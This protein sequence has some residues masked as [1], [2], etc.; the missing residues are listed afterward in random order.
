LAPYLYDAEAG[1]GVSPAF[2]GNTN[3]TG[4]ECNL[5]ICQ[6]GGCSGPGEG[7]LY[8]TEKVA[9]VHTTDYNNDPTDGDGVGAYEFQ[10][11]FDSF[12]IQ[13][14]NPQDLVF[15]NNGSG[16]VD[17]GGAPFLAGGRGAPNCSMS[18]T[19]ENSVRF[20]CVTVG[21]NDGPN[22]N[23]DLALLNLIPAADDV[24]DLFPGNDNG[25]P[26]LIK[27]NQCELA[28][29]LGHPVKNTVGN[30][31]QLPVCGDLYVTVRILEGDLNLD[32]RVDVAD[33]ALIASHYGSFFGSAFYQKWF[34]LEPRF[35][36][37]DIDIKDLQK[38]FGRDGSTCADPIPQQ[39]P[40]AA[41]FD[42]NS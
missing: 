8:V 28:D 23:F 29:I 42:L 27:D 9:N 40:V 3:A 4:N 12:V 37:L 22:G 10:V 38:V 30:A 6:T 20:G 18:I 16:T 35:H 36:D 31:G 2:D 39:T 14:V 17:G 33:E 41:P 25:I 13:S 7:H 5:F 24:K 19:S 34:D 26:T 15:S 1:P 21:Q 32:C 11:E